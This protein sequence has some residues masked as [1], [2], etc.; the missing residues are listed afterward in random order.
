MG[1]GWTRVSDFGFVAHKINASPKDHPK[2]LKP[3][4][5]QAEQNPPTTWLPS[6][7][8]RT[9]GKLTKIA[10]GISRL[11]F[12]ILF[13]DCSGLVRVLPS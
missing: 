2:K 10:T 7:A 9:Q 6:S 4:Q 1:A 8:T 3:L 12:A 11:F 13:A 5:H